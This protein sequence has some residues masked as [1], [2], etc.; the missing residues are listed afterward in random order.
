MGIKFVFLHC[1]VPHSCR[2]RH[3]NLAELLL[4]GMRMLGVT[5]ME[6]KKLVKLVIDGRPLCWVC[7]RLGVQV[8]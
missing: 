3:K 8:F 7:Q 5:N 2:K 1:T 4:R 6:A